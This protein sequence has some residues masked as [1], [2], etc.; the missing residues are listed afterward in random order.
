MRWNSSCRSAVCSLSCVSVTGAYFIDRD[1]THFR[2]ILNFLRGTFDIT[3]VPDTAI[4][5]LRAEAEFYRL[6]DMAEVLTPLTYTA[7]ECKGLL[8][9]LG[10]S[11][12][13]AAYANPATSGVV[14][15]VASKPESVVGTTVALVGRDEGASGYCN[16]VGLNDVTVSIRRSFLPS[17]YSLKS[18]CGTTGCT[19]SYHPSNWVLEGL[20]VS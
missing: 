7:G 2:H 3:A 5:E 13:R 12:G 6:Y 20:W 9:H 14:T 17:G 10:S 15:V 1:G 4:S 8:Y 11:F 16:G 18:G 19:C